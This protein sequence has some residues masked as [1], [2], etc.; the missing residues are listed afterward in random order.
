[1]AEIRCVL[2][3]TDSRD[4]GAAGV[5]H[6]VQDPDA[7]FRLCS[8]KFRQRLCHFIAGSVRGTTTLCSYDSMG[9]AADESADWSPDAHELTRTVG[10]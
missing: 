6:A 9:S 7:L 1:L 10:R 5:V 8:L 3:Q 2:P 4:V